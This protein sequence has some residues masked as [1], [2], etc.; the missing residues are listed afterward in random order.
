MAGLAN[1]SLTSVD[2]DGVTM[3]KTVGRLLLERIEGRT[4]S[5]RFSVTPALVPRRST[6]PPPPAR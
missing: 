4:A 1:V 5:V 6:G 2:Q 3:G